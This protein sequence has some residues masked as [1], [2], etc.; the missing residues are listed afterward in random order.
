MKQIFTLIK[1]VQLSSLTDERM[2]RN[3]EKCEEKIRPPDSYKSKVNTVERAAPKLSKGRL[4]M[5]SGLPRNGVR[6]P[7]FPFMF[8]LISP[9]PLISE[10]QVVPS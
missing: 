4:K 5:E 10:R 2:R 1:M 6:G 7:Y 8:L 9:Q 3:E